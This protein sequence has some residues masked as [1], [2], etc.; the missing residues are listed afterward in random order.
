MLNETW[1]ETLI[2][3]KN[4]DKSTA[5]GYRPKFRYK[6]LSSADIKSMIESSIERKEARDDDSV[7]DFIYAVEILDAIVAHMISN[8]LKSTRYLVDYRY[9]CRVLVVSLAM[10]RGLNAELCKNDTRYIIVN[11]F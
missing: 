8:D 6:D 3:Y 7:N 11:C 5:W 4:T 9:Q 2:R 10:K 1:Q